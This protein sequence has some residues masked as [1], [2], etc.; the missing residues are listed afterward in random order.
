MTLIGTKSA[1]RGIEVIGWLAR[2]TKFEVRCGLRG[3]SGHF[4]DLIFCHLDWDDSFKKFDE[5]LRCY[6]A[7]KLNIILLLDPW[8]FQNDD[9]GL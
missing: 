7:Q 9:E 2:S 6:T 1:S 3:L 4:D 5:I 8:D